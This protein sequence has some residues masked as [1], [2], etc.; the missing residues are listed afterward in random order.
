MYIYQQ[1]FNR[2]A[3]MTGFFFATM[4]EAQPFIR[5]TDID[6]EKLK[7]TGWT[8]FALSGKPYVAGIC[9]MGIQSA[10]ENL[11]RFLHAATITEVINIGICGSLNETAEVQK[12][13]TVT[14]TFLWQKEKNGSYRPTSPLVHNLAFEN[15]ILATVTE[16]LFDAALRNRIGKHADLVD[17]EGAA[18]ASV[19][20]E[21][22]IPWGMVKGVSDTASEGQKKH[23]F[24]NI[25]A[26]S[27][28]LA[29]SVINVIHPSDEASAQ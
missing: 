1:P 18:I 25:D 13:Y 7:K 20:S 23:L 24:E 9:G 26:L 17:M 21:L 6:R 28:R 3:A 22:A 8:Q 12:M 19:C 10:R 29:T 14:E 27:Q 5:K 11:T 15:K 16:P 4:R 2:G